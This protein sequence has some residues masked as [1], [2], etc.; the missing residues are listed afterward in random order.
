MLSRSK[1]AL[2]GVL[3]T[4]LAG[5]FLWRFGDSTAGVDRGDLE[6]LRGGWQRADLALPA[7][8]AELPG[9]AGADDGLPREGAFLVNLWASYCVPCKEEMPWLERLATSTDVPVRG[10]TR[11]NLLDEARKAMRER[12]VTYPNVR[13]E[14]GDFMAEL[15]DVIPPQFVPSSFL[16]EDGRITWVHVGPF[17]SYADLRDSVAERL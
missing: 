1:L 5:A 15:T 12:K 8:G 6:Q 11:D 4:L 10:V 14:Y 16:V 13:D 9:I 2:V 3:V 17:R 7:I